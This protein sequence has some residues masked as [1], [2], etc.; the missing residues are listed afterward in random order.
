[1]KV[2]SFVCTRLAF[3]LLFAVLPGCRSMQPTLSGSVVLSFCRAAADTERLAPTETIGVVV[4]TRPVFD[5]PAL[6]ML[7]RSDYSPSDDDFRSAQD[8]QASVRVAFRSSRIRLPH[9]LEGLPCHFFPIKTPEWARIEGRLVVEFSGVVHNPYDSP[10]TGERGVFARFSFQGQG[11]SWYWIPVT[12]KGEA[13]GALGAQ[14]LGVVE[15]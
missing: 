14:P 10:R 1:M 3:G 2:L 7:S 8:Y 15:D 4:N 11:G 6:M 12:D 5:Y 13:D 9:G